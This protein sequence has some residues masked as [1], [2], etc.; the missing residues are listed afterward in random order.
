MNLELRELTM[1]AQTDIERE[2][3]EARRKGQ[4]DY[5]TDMRAERRMGQ[6][7]GEARGEAMA[8]IRLLQRLLKRPVITS[9]EFGAMSIEELT[10]LEAKLT[11]TAR[12][13]GID[14]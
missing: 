1:L 6:A 2:K 5:T 14:L 8:T 7:E 3:Y 9:E 11:A 4:L 10:A 13:S 12:Q